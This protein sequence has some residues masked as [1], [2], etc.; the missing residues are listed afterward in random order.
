MRVTIRVAGLVMALLWMLASPAMADE[1]DT[2]TGTGVNPT[3]VTTE[4]SSGGT[5]S[6][7]GN[8][9][10]SPEGET[11]SKCPGAPEGECFK[12]GAWWSSSEA[13]YARP[14]DAE[15][16]SVVWAQVA[17]DKTSGS[18]VQCVDGMVRWIPEGASTIPDARQLALTAANKALFAV[19]AVQ[20]APAREYPS[21]VHLQNW[22]WVPETQWVDITSTAAVGPTSVT[23]RG[24]PVRIEWDLGNADTTSCSTAGRAWTPAMTDSDDTNCEYS[25]DTVSASQPGGVYRLSARIV[26]SVTWSC[27]GAC[28]SPGG[29]LGEYPSPAGTGCLTVYE[30]QSVVTDSKVTA[31]P[32]KSLCP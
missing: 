3:G 30:L 13:C 16:G 25:Y 11:A 18:L 21:Y 17:G 27:S 10:N 15:V 22:L 20:T 29:D 14:L 12:D 32:G 9:T 26:Y 8:G 5:V 7:E 24:K 19:P 6:S 4:V 28:T 2:S 31:K 23:A 1:G